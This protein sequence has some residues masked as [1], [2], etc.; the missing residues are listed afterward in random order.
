VFVV[1]VVFVVFLVFVVFKILQAPDS[2]LKTHNTFFQVSIAAEFY[3]FDSTDPKNTKNSSNSIIPP[4][5][6]SA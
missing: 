1:F 5:G 6:I 4:R 3:R 2:Q